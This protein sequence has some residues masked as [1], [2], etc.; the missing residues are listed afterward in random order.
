MTKPGS[1][2]NLAE[3]GKLEFFAPDKDKFPSLEFADAALRAGGTSPAVMNAANEVAVERFCAGEIKFSGIWKIVGEV[4]ESMT[5]EPQESL[6][7]ILEADA[8]AR[9]RAKEICG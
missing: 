2:L 4:M 9:A 8:E 3:M 6:E 1:N 5:V 7:Q